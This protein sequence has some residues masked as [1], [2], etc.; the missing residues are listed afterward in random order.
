MPI[1]KT[2]AKG[3]VVIPAEIRKKIGLKPGR[4][5]LITVES[6]RRI[7]LEP[8][9]EDPIRDLRGVLRG[10]P[11]LTRALLQERRRDRQHEEKKFARLIR[12]HGLAS[13]RKGRSDG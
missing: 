3:Q 11:S 10:G 6:E 5:V 8:L 1:V 7:A 12:R 4:K 13:K 9:S 2:L